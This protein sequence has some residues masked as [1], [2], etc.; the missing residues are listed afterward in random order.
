MKSNLKRGYGFIA[1][2]SI[3]VGLMAASVSPAWARNSNPRVI[4][5]NAKAYG[6]TYGEWTAK[7]WQWAFSLPVSQNPFFDENGDCTNGA[8]G[9]LG[10]VW[11]LTGVVNV[12]GTAERN[13]TVPAGKSLFFPIFNTECSTLEGNGSTEAELRTCAAGLVAPITG[14]EAEID[15]VSI[16]NLQEN[17]RA[18]SPLFTYGPLPDDNVLQLFGY[19]APA[20][21]T[22]MSVADGF[23]LMLTPLSVGQHAIHFTGSVPGFTLNIIYNIT[24]TPAK[25]Q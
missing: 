23:Y 8:N 22:S 21:A 18:A 3:V 12:S 4:P 13:C 7:W 19:T 9:Q 15:G 2:I 10:P 11:F 1:V 24:V 16:Q 14:L 25:K 6:M 5:P 17:Y 20:G